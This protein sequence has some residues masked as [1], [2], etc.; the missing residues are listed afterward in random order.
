MTLIETAPTA[1][2][3]G[4]DE[5]PFVEIGGGNKLKVLQV[6]GEPRASGSSRT[7]SRPASRSRR[8]R[9]T[10]PV[11]GYTHVGRVEVQGVRLR[12]PGRVVP[13]RAGRVGAHA[14]GRRG[15]HPVWFHMYGANLNL[16]A[17]G[18][19]ESV[20]D[21]AGDARRDYL[22]C[23]RPRASPPERPGRLKSAQSTLRRASDAF[24]ARP[25]ARG[26]RRAAPDAARLLAGHAGPA[27][28]LGGAE[29]RRRRARGPR[30]RPVLGLRGR[31]RARGPRPRA[32]RDDAQHAAGDGPAAARR[33]TAGRSPPRFKAK[34]IAGLED[35]IRAMCR[36][37][38]GR[39]RREGRRR[40]RARRHRGRCRTQVIGELVGP[41]RARTGRTSTTWP[42][43]NTRGQD[44]DVN[45]DGY[46][47]PS[48]ENASAS[49]WPC[50][51]SSFARSG[52]PSR[53]ATT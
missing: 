49:T 52:A 13:V 7:S 39:R 34:V 30:A 46:D 19:I 32:A 11:W 5:M 33:P 35:R 31:R 26:A 28:L 51:P 3:L 20:S 22:A 8:H 29:A 23:A 2:H 53:A 48:G 44:P 12:E 50:T 45:P 43:C 24:V 6:E 41:A 1:V 9:H 18:N 15:R 47:K 17:D 38:P 14:A 21:G 4:A 37:D 16:D 42:R 25:A 36:D 27:G 10:G 40:V